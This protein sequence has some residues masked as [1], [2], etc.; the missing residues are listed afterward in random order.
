M[1]ARLRFI[2]SEPLFASRTVDVLLL[3]LCALRWMPLRGATRP[4]SF[5]YDSPRLRLGRRRLQRLRS[6]SCRVLLISERLISGAP[7]RRCLRFRFELDVCL[8]AVAVL[9]SRALGLLGD[10]RLL[11]H[12]LRPPLELRGRLA[13]SCGFERLCGGPARSARA[14]CTWC[15]SPIANSATRLVD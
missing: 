3:V 7:H 11:S 14:A 9:V 5:H 6:L 15:Q 13:Q 12:Q 1:F 4:T 10:R 8:L 2:G